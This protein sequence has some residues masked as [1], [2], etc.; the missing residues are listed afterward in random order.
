MSDGQATIRASYLLELGRPADAVSLLAAHLAEHPN[1]AE[2]WRLVA[3]ARLA[4]GDTTEAIYAA[5]R[6]AGLAPQ[7]VAALTMLS[8]AQRRVGRRDEAVATARAAVRLAPENPGALRVLAEALSKHRRHRKEALEVATEA[9]RLAPDSA[10]SYLAIGNVALERGDMW[11]ARQC[12]TRALEIEP[13]HP[14]ARNNLAIVDL[15]NGDP[16]EALRGFTASGG[17]NPRSMFPRYNVDVAVYRVIHR[18]MLAVLVLA[19][20]AAGKPSWPV[21]AVVLPIAVVWGVRWVRQLDPA[22]RPLVRASLRSFPTVWFMLAL[23]AG[24]CVVLLPL[25]LLPPEQAKTVGGAVVGVALLGL[26]ALH[27]ASKALAQ[28]RR[29]KA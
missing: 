14:A 20:V 24:V 13:N 27:V 6:A 5:R 2:A 10:E 29:P 7:S 17:M 15:R 16:V 26:T 1:D 8:V 9:M 3:S 18:V 23:I 19:F 4:Q 21:A 22:L 28:S 11:R 12:F 25:P